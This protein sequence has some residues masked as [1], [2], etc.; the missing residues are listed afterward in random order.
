MFLKYILIYSSKTTGNIY[1]GELFNTEL[2]TALLSAGGQCYCSYYKM[3][4]LKLLCMTPKCR[5]A[6]WSLDAAEMWLT[7]VPRI[8]LVSVLAQGAAEQSVTCCTS[9]G[10]AQGVTQAGS[11]PG[12]LTKPLLSATVT[13]FC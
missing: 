3:I 9:G 7:Q 12:A 6:R 2:R 8:Y 5:R 10:R 13:W 1:L 11:S 4:R